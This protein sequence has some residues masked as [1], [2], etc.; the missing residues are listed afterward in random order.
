[1]NQHPQE[2]EGRNQQDK[3][4]ELMNEQLF[5]LKIELVELKKEQLELKRKVNEIQEH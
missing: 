1:M 3:I 4:R 5:E 2:M